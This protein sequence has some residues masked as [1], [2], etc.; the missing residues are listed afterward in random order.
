MDHAVLAGSD[1]DERAEAGRA[2][3]DALKLAVDLGVVGDELDGLARLCDHVLVGAGDVDV[4]EVVDVDLD[5]GLVDDLVDRLAAAADDLSD[6]VGVDL[7]GDDLGRILGQVRSRSRQNG[8]HLAEDLQPAVLRLGESLAQDSL[9]DALD[10]DVHL[11]RGD[12]LGG[13]C[14]LEVHVAE[15][16]LKPLDVGEHLHLGLVFIADES[17]RDAGDR[18][19]ERN[20]CVHQSERGAADGCLRGA[21]V[22]G[23]NFADRADRVREAVLGREHGLERPFGE[24]AVTDLAPSRALHRLGFADAVRRE[25]VVVD[26]SLADFVV[27]TVELLHLGDAAQ[28]AAGQDLGL[29]SGEHA[30]AVNSRQDARFAPN[31]SDLGQL[32]AV[33]TDA[34]VEDLGADLLFLHRVE[35]FADVLLAL[36]ELLFEMSVDIRVEVFFRLLSLL[37]V[38]VLEH[39]VHLLVRIRSDS[40]VDLFGGM[41]EVGLEL[42]LAHLL[43]NVLDERDDLLDLFVTEQNRADH[44]L[45]G[46]L[47]GARFDHQ[48]RLFGAAERQVQS[49]PVT[50]LGVGV[51][52]ILT[53]DI[54]DDD[55]TG[56]P[57]PRNVRNGQRDRAADHRIHFGRNVGVHRKAGRDDRD[58]IVEA[59]GEQRTERSVDQSRRQDRLV[60]GSALAL[61]ETAGDLAD[62][63]H[64]LLKVYAEREKVDALARSLRHRRVDH[65]GGVAASDQAA[66][67]GLFAVSAD[68]YGHFPAAD[69]G[70]KNLSF[71]Y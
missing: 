25:V 59:L 31:G 57:R 5:A 64:L 34:V 13:A 4:A 56:R 55:R 70:G 50:L 18:S 35:N 39:L 12:T 15:E 2:D 53:V 23:Q 38:K 61:F 46:Q 28:R 7:E 16:V 54:A 19:L 20:A 60:A 11:D 30:A 14:D 63:V 69:D 62:G 24:R 52:H 36:G 26:V 68:L 67:V 32:S 58:V 51:D 40:R 17:H 22:A 33:G 3:D 45:F 71:H 29:S 21:A 66:A 44:L 9:V 8:E 47:V 49:A 42:G 6:L 48:D 43:L 10:L 27:E 41:I 1:L 65:D 37:S